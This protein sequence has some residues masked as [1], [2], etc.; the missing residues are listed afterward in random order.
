MIMEKILI[1]FIKGVFI[2]FMYYQITTENDTNF[3][4]IVSFAGFY[5]IV[6]HSAILAGIDPIIITNAYMTK[7][8]FTIVDQRLSKT[9]SEQKK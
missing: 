6:L 8:V 4:N 2:A 5:V 3:N 9:N 1:D 7:M